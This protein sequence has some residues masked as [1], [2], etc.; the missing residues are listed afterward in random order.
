MS[1]ITTVR[2]LAL[3]AALP[4]LAAVP[5]HAE[6]ADLRPAG[7]ASAPDRPRTAAL[8]LPPA[9]AIEAGNASVLREVAKT[10]AW[11]S[12]I[13][14]DRLADRMAAE[15]GLVVIDARSP[16][17]YAANHLPG[18]I[19]LPGAD[20][21]TPAAEPGAGDSQYVFRTSDGA[22]DIARYEKLLGDAGLTRD[23]AVV[24][25]GNHAGKEDGSVPAML[26]DW[27]GQRD[28]TFLDGVGLAQWAA[29]GRQPTTEPRT[30][31]PATYRAEPKADFVWN[32][33]EVLD[34]VG[35]PGVVF[36]DTRTADEFAGTDPGRRNNRFGGHIPGAVDLDYASFLADNKTTL[37]KSEL[38][39]E[40]ERHGVTPDKTVVLYCQTATRVSLPYLVLK[41]LGYPKV[42]VY[43]ASWHEYGNRDD[44]PKETGAE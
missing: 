32:L 41:D 33:P 2:L 37:S 25:Y 13:T 6:S 36:Y 23:A 42:A 17:Q 15:P 44:T 8:S 7:R 27:L 21:R 34:H 1:R 28:V 30:L 40:L 24:I 39:A 20:L 14:A 29:S 11:D 18:A 10:S 19:N 26:L 16:E 43:D 5:V 4:L 3:A 9:P 31:P 12:L 38:K 35:D 22:P